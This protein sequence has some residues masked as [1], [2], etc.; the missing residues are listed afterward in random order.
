MEYAYGGKNDDGSER[1]PGWREGDYTEQGS[2]P[3]DGRGRMNRRE[4]DNE[5]CNVDWSYGAHIEKKRGPGSQNIPGRPFKV[6]FGSFRAPAEGRVMDVGWLKEVGYRFA[7]TAPFNWQ[8]MSNRI[9][10]DEEKKN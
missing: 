6:I 10:V 5:P 2:W 4:R 8:N 1:F 3:A 9:Y 7:M